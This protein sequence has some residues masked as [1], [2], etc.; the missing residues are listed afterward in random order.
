[1]LRPS[2]YPRAA[3]VGEQAKPNREQFGNT[4]GCQKFAGLLRTFVRTWG[5]TSER[6]FATRTGESRRRERKF[7][8]DS[9]CLLEVGLVASARG[10]VRVNGRVAAWIGILQ[11]FETFLSS[12]STRF[13]NLRGLKKFRGW[14]RRIRA[15]RRLG[16]CNCKQGGPE[17]K[18]ESERGPYNMDELQRGGAVPR[19]DQG[20]QTSPLDGSKSA[21]TAPR[22]R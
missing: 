20:V 12:A 14:P 4:R 22:V 18:S 3:R 8:N 10:G 16:G 6:A 9:S 17:R 11:R 1:M 21:A 13:G 2:A 5:W 19:E 15:G 7:K